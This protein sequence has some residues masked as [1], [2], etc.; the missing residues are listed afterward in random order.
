MCAAN[1]FHFICNDMIDVSMI[2]KNDI[3]LTNDGTIGKQT[4]ANHQMYNVGIKV[5]Q[6][7]Y[8]ANHTNQFC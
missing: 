2:W 6:S 4:R 8:I 3:H 5:N 1:G 7:V